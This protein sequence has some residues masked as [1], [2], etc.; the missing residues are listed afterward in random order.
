M[1]SRHLPARRGVSLPAM[2]CATALLA[3]CGKGPAAPA[4]SGGGVTAVTAEGNRQ[5]VI[6]PEGLHQLFVF[7]I[8]EAG[9]VRLGLLQGGT[10]CVTQ[11]QAG[12]VWPKQ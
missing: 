8:T 12:K 1:N 2:I 5:V 3:A 9:S 11:V 10:V 7:D 4:A 6:V